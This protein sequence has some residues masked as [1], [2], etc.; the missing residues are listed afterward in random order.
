MSEGTRTPDR[1]DHNPGSSGAF[2]LFSGS[3]K[4]LSGRQLRPRPPGL[5]SVPESVPVPGD[6]ELAVRVLSGESFIRSVD[7]CTPMTGKAAFSDSDGYA[8]TLDFLAQ[9]Y[10]LNAEDAIE[11]AIEFKVR[12]RDH[13]IPLSW[14][15][16][17]QRLMTCSA[18]ALRARAARAR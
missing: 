2:G 7:D 8:R 11:T 3:V 15:G 18:A 5:T 14:R 4:R 13:T 6:V 12:S 17:P 9:P 1:R 10:G 16:V